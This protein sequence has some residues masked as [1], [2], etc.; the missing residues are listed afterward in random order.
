ML[1][2]ATPASA[3]A[4]QKYEPFRTCLVGEAQSQTR[5]DE[6]DRAILERARSSCFAANLASGSAAMFAEIN[7]GATKEQ[8]LERVARLRE[9]AEAEALA[10]IRAVKASG[11]P[12]PA[13]PPIERRGVVLG[14]LVIPDAIAPA[15]MPYLVCV[16]A[17][18]GHPVYTDS[19]KRLAAPSPEAGDCGALRAKAGRDAD[20]LLRRQGP[21]DE[22]ARRSLIEKTLND[23]DAFERDSSLPPSRT[24][25]DAPN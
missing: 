25:T 21:G 17:K 15:V 9:E 6:E 5:P 13:A 8:A 2:A 18:A 24:G 14:R 11:A 7:K 3:E 10:A 22:K 20:E 16:G 19:G 4:R 1:Q 12:A 23:V